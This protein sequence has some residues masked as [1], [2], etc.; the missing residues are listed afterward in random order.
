MPVLTTPRLVLRAFTP[1]DWRDLHAYLSQ[2]QVVKFEPYEVFTEEEC[3]REAARRAGDGAFWAVCLKE[4]G[5]LIGNVYF[6]Q[7]EPDEFLTWEIG[8]VFNPAY[9]GKGYATESC[10]ALMDYGFN[11][12]GARRIMARCNTLNAP[13]WRLL[14]RLG[15]RREGHFLK[16]AFF[17]RDAQGRPLWQDA[18]EYAILAAEWRAKQ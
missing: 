9:G 13:S 12:L 1:D 4:G 2:K 18:Y 10:R 16:V 14:E 15:M 6:K 11:Q 7:Q 3:R 5:R 8:Y 17:K